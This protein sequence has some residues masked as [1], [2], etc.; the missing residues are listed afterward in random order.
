MYQYTRHKYILL[1]DRLPLDLFSIVL[2]FIG[3][4][5]VLDIYDSD[6]DESDEDTYHMVLPKKVYN[7]LRYSKYKDVLYNIKRSR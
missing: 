3:Y 6:E 4:D 1:F 7:K 5:E 2:N